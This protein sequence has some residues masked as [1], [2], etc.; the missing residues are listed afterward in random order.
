MDYIER[1][2][3]EAE[4]MLNEKND[5]FN[6]VRKDGYDAAIES[7]KEVYEQLEKDVLEELRHEHRSKLKDIGTSIEDERVNFWSKYIVF[8]VSY[9]LWLPLILITIVIIIV[10]GKNFLAWDW[11]LPIVLSLLAVD[12]LA[13][14][15]S[16]CM[17]K[18]IIKRLVEKY[19]LYGVAEGM[20]HLS[21]Y[22][23]LEAFDFSKLPDLSNSSQEEAW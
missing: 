3:E 20:I 5:Y 6:K 4:T 10:A 21:D 18:R 15:W 19:A 11:V 23:N 1:V 14:L 13:W 8:S 7:Q 9:V 12:I 2:I 22:R 17:L 16:T